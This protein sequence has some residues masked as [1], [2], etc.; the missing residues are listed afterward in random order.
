[1]N[2]VSL[3]TLGFGAVSTFLESVLTRIILGASGLVAV[4]VLASA[5]A[6]FLK[7]VGMAT[8]GWM[9]TVIGVSLTLMIGV[10]ILCFVGLALTILMGSQT[11]PAPSANYR[12]F[13][14]RISKFGVPG[15]SAARPLPSVE[16][17]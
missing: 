1:M 16:R 12:S 17:S 13:I 8:P 15:T 5:V 14:A 4:S 9:T 3:V 11:V 10:A 2:F 7:L 6:I